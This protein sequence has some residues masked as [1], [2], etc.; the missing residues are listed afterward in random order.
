MARLLAH[1]KVESLPD[2][3]WLKR[4]FDTGYLRQIDK[5]ITIQHRDRWLLANS[6]F[7][8]DVLETRDADALA[9][10]D[11]FAEPLPFIVF[12]KKLS[13]RFRVNLSNPTTA[14]L[15]RMKL[16]FSTTREFVN[17]RFVVTE[18]FNE[19]GGLQKMRQ[20]VVGQPRFAGCAYIMMSLDCNFR[21]PGCFIYR[22]NWKQKPVSMMSPETFEHLHGFVMRMIP[23]GIKME[24]TYVYYGGEPL[25]NKPVIEYAARRIRELQKEGKYGR[26]KPVMMIITNG[27]LIDDELIRIVKTYDIRIAVSLDGVG[28]AHDAN[29]AFPGG[30]STFKA[31]LAGI[32]RLEKAGIDY[33]IPYTV[34]PNNID[35]V[36]KDVLWMVRHLKTKGIA[37]NIMRDLSGRIFQKEGEASFFKKMHHIYDVLL[38]HGITEGRLQQ[39][40][41]AGKK[42]WQVLPHPFCCAAVGGGQFVMRPDGK[43]GICHWGVMQEGEP[44]WQTPEEIGE[45]L[46]DPVYLEWLARTPVFIKRCYEGCNYFGYCPGGCAYRASK[47][48]GTMYDVSE[49]LCMVERF[50]MERAIIEDHWEGSD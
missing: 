20:Y 14:E 10:L 37:F 2:Y 48:K 44:Q 40:R 1:K 42:R 49:D 27:S 16:L 3:R 28:K 31:V 17:H 30:G 7:L 18:A 8:K 5:F 26:I 34:G 41:C 32:R 4:K 38:K 35:A 47:A 39:Y 23:K 11:L 33:D 36:A 24:F 21:C 12:L 13:D 45:F 19:Q 29:R 15:T 25:L 22:G 46:K 6:F 43:I 9:L 50:L